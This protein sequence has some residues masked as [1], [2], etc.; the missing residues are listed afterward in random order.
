MINSLLYNDLSYHKYHWSKNAINHR[1]KIV[2]RCIYGHSLKIIQPKKIVRRENK[3]EK[4]YN[5]K[6]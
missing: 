6:A 2:F 1:V 4:E 3:P 5:Q